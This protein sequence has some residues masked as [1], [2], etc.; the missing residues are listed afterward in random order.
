[1]LVVVFIS[2]V[3]G[4]NAVL[5]LVE[6]SP[7]HIVAPIQNFWRDMHCIGL[8]RR[9]A[10]VWS[11][12]RAVRLQRYYSGVVR[13]LLHPARSP[14]KGPAARAVAAAMPIL[15]QLCPARLLGRPVVFPW[16]V[17]PGGSC[18]DDSVS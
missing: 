15:Q 12:G 3:A 14:Q 2:L 5:K 11:R 13:P 4:I 10:P 17:R 8:T 6:L 16:S 18:G 7:H 1:M 9:P